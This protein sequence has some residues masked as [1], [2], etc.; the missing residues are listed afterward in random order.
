[1]PQEVRVS[2]EL[3]FAKAPK[4]V[5]TDELTDSVCYAQ[6]SEGIRAKCEAQGMEY[7]LIERM[8]YD[9]YDVVREIAG[10]GTK[11]GVIVHKVRPPVE[12]LRG[13]SVFCCGDFAL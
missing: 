10:S 13:G 7:R 12:N 3:R 4:A 2:V 5:T 11:I 1:M 8:A 9:I 6:I